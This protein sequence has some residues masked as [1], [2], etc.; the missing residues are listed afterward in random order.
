MKKGRCAV[1]GLAISYYKY[2]SNVLCQRCGATTV[3]QP[4]EQDE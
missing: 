3:P 4:L 2:A 1:C